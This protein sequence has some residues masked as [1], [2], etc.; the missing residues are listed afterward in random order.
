[1]KRVSFH[2]FVSEVLKNA[3]YRKG[4]DSNCIVAI[5]PDLPGCITQGDN[6]E[7]AREN[8]IDAVELWLT[9]SLRDGEQ[10]PPVSGKVLITVSQK[11]PKLKLKSVHA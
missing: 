6:F 11:P 9:S 4:K 3:E 10:I 7:E 5:A 8:L 1:M 2:E